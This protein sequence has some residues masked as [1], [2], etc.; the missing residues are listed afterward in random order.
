MP[1]V[2]TI[3]ETPNVLCF[4]VDVSKPDNAGGLA[5][6]VIVVLLLVAT[7]IAL[8]V[9]YLRT[10]RGA[11][12]GLSSSSSSPSSDTAGFNNEIYEPEPVVSSSDSR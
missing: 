4:F 1:A 9:Y 11:G 8:L 2:L 3:L 10:R 12:A 5:A 6:S 7:L